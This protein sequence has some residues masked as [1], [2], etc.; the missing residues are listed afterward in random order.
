MFIKAQQEFKGTLSPPK[1]GPSQRELRAQLRAERIEQGNVGTMSAGEHNAPGE[2]NMT[3][4]EAAASL[5]D[6]MAR[7]Q[8]Q[9]GIL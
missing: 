6:L 3:E 9:P 1:A 5:V 7:E 2:V 4:L 8:L